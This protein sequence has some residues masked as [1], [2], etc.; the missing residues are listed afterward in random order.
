MIGII[1]IWNISKCSK[2]YFLF[3]FNI[4]FFYK[5]KNPTKL[6]EINYV[7]VILHRRHNDVSSSPSISLVV[8]VD[9]N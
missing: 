5:F 7:D 8:I 1:G 6:E 3:N 4:F 2:C 9:F